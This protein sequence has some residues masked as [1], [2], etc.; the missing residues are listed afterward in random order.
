MDFTQE[1]LDVAIDTSD[2]P[3]FEGLDA[4]HISNGTS[5][6]F[7]PGP[8]PWVGVLGDPSDNCEPSGLD[9]VYDPSLS[10]GKPNVGPVTVSNERQL[11]QADEPVVPEEHSSQ[12]PADV[13]QADVEL[14]GGE[15]DVSLSGPPTIRGGGNGCPVGSQAKGV[16]AGAYGLE[17]SKKV[18]IVLPVLGCAQV[19]IK[20]A[21]VGGFGEAGEGEGMHDP[22]RSVQH[23]EAG[24]G[25][26]Q[27][28]EDRRKVL[29]G[30][31]PLSV[32]RSNNS[33]L[34]NVGSKRRPA[35]GTQEWENFEEDCVHA[36]PLPVHPRTQ[37][38]TGILSPILSRYTLT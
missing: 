15:K 8:N 2:T 18:P 20:H 27:R 26:H 28:K 21:E 12:A 9:V 16:E 33:K 37:K 4:V 22:A 32:D 14:G 35:G 31:Y 19:D 13:V 6:P 36:S 24:E 3:Q 30:T 1:A 38:W 5:Y 7:E 23:R 10:P 34:L 17:Q 25:G 29:E 11:M